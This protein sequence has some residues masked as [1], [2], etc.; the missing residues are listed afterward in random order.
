M[1]ELMAGIAAVTGRS[2]TAEDLRQFTTYLD[3]F[4]RWNRVHRM[5]A[6]DSPVAIV[7][8]LFLD[9]L[10]FL[11]VLPA[12]ALSVVDLGAGAGIPGLPMRLAQPQIRMTLVESKR[13]RV[14]FLRTVCRELGLV[15]VEV[16]EGRAELL[17]LRDPELGGV[18]DVAVSR[19]VRAPE[20]LLP[21]ALPY[22]KP[23]G[24][25]VVSGPPGYS[26]HHGFDEIRVHAPGKSRHRRFLRAR[27][28]S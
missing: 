2:A 15:D 17:A 9:S 23:G 10:L 1:K 16:E 3:L 20:A 7:R 25:L 8:E 22:L 5:T 14:S 4:V 18:F 24:I 6:L 12:G 26:D 27:K 13:K 19:A 28:G 11:S 21:L